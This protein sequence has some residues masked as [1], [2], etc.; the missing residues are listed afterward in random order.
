MTGGVVVTS[1]LLIFILLTVY[2]MPKAKKTLPVVKKEK[3][4]RPEIAVV[5]TEPIESKQ[6]LVSK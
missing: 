3:G 4:K 6:K 5:G 2:A 1:C